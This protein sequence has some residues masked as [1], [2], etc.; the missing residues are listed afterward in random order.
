MSLDLVS[1][2]ANSEEAQRQIDICNACRYC[3]G[4][5]SVFQAISRER[6]FDDGDMTQLA[7]LCHNCRN[8]YYA[9]QYTPPHEFALNIP[10]ILGKVRA[11]SWERLARPQR[12]AQIFQTHGTA[13][14]GLMVVALA[15]FFWLM[16]AFKPLSG[17]GFYAYLAHNAMIALFI[18]AFLGPLVLIGLSLRAYWV[19][20][21][22]GRI[23]LRHLLQA[24]NLAARMRNLD[25]GHGDGCNYEAG[26][27]FTLRRFWA[28][29]LTMWGFV[30]CFA[31]TSS[32]TIMHYFFAWP[33]PYGFWTPP[34][35]F[36]VPGGLMLVAGTAGLAWLKLQAPREFGAERV[37]GGEMAFV[38]LLGLTGL[39]GLVLYAATGTAA[40]A[41][42]LALHLA[43]VMTLFL[44]MPFS[45]MVHIFYRM[46]ALV[47][48]A[49]KIAP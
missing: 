43:A 12:L 34:K 27:R 4:F 49:V 45:K 2:A 20:I 29:Q 33:A 15:A 5:C 42:M 25:G 14:A 17:D 1:M 28:H 39:S 30:L 3:E 18:P 23:R 47:A 9:C 32:G 24:T 26:D 36:G 41:P 21:G 44:L 48:D 22:G 13:M 46:A 38:L 19:E 37:W 6:S 40:V 10:E 7:N 8:C 31:A 35:L 11:D 16:H